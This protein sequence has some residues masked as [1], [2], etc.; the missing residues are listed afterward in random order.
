MPEIRPFRGI[1]YNPSA[2]P[3]EAVVAPPYDV[4]SPEEQTELY[5]RHPANIVR[6]ILG[7]EVNR[8]ES[9]ARHFSEW[10]ASGVLN[11]D[12]GPSIYLLRQSFTLDGAQI[13]RKGFI[14]ACRLE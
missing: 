13:E 12:S 1:L 5:E 9:A 8:Y 14:A 2:V 6:L 11:R 3:M 4:I 10:R 7:R